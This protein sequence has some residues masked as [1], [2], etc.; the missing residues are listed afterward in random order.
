MSITAKDFEAA[1][2]KGVDQPYVNWKGE[3][4]VRTYDN[5]DFWDSHG[6]QSPIEIPGLGT[7][8]H[9]DGE[10]GGEGSAEYIWQVWKIGEQY[11]QKTG[12][13]MSYDGST[14]DGDLTEVEPFEK[15][16]T[17]WRSKR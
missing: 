12:Y 3:D 14:W 11:F 13:Y 16:V 9:I 5:Y 10:H 8:T 2:E 7:A 6:G 1:L 15:T 17:D 4:D